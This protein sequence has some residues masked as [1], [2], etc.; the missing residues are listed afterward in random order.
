MAVYNYALRALKF[1]QQRAAQGKPV[2]PLEKLVHKLTGEV[3][4]WFDL[5]AGTLEVGK[6]ADVVVVDPTHLDHHL[7]EIKQACMPEFGGF[8]RLVRRNPRAVPAVLVGGEIVV[9]EGEVL[10][11]VGR[12]VGPGRF[13]R[14][15]TA[16]GPRVEPEAP[17]SRDT[18]AA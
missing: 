6:R 7:D 4:A 16:S 18:A 10:P 12:S 17:R 9:R 14:A 8:E 13:V 15:R 3:G 11:E 5:D 2:M 1:V